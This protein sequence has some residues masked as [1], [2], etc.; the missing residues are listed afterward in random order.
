MSSG[1][2]SGRGL[3]IKWNINIKEEIMKS[4]RIS[5]EWA[6]SAQKVIKDIIIPLMNNGV[7]PVDGKRMF[8][9]YK[10]PKKYPAA[11][12]SSN[13]P[14]LRLTGKLYSNYK[15]APVKEKEVG[16]LMGI[17]GGGDKLRVYAEANNIGTQDAKSK[18][19][20]AKLK[21]LQSIKPSS[22]ASRE[23]KSA[24]KLLKN[25]Y[26]SM[27]KGIPERRFIPI[28]GEKYNTKIMLALREYLASILLRA[29]N[30]NKEKK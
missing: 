3:N 11:I 22:D 17:Q 18:S 21:T 29:I 8:D 13:K 30:R 6:A 27:I 10:D 23:T 24:H 26:K 7:S 14:N 9:K 19:M 20:K 2:K 1:F 12:K 28:L 15:A 25:K 4:D 16:I 5:K